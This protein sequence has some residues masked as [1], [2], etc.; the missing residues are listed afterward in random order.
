[1]I[2]AIA[3]ISV[4]T[5][6]DVSHKVVKLWWEG[7]DVMVKIKL[8]STPAGEIAKKLVMEGVAIGLS[9]RGL[10]SVKET[11]DGNIV[12]NDFAL[13]CW[14]IVLEPSVQGAFMK[15][16]ETKNINIFSKAD[17]INRMINEILKK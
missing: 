14:D 8:L 3:L 11:T 17:K 13:I 9:S 2:W 6:V 10:G 12:E 1:M 4:R 5:A 7:K 16:N 15:M